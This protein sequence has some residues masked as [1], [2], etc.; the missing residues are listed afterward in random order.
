[1]KTWQAK[2]ERKKTYT[3][4]QNKWKPIDGKNEFKLINT[5]SQYK[6]IIFMLIK[7]IVSLD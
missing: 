3:K 1:M 6:Q 7:E 5:H 2:R 4:P